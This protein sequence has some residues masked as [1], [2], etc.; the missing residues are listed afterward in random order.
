MKKLITIFTSIAAGLLFGAA[1]ANE[2]FTTGTSFESL[3]LGDK[4]VGHLVNYGDDGTQAGAELYWLC[5]ADADVE[6]GIITNYPA[7]GSDVPIESRPDLFTESHSNNCNYLSIDLNK[8]TP[9]LR[10]IKLYNDSVTPGTQ[11]VAVADCANGIFLDTL[12]KF[13]AAEEA[14]KEDLTDGD[15]IAIEYVEQEAETNVVNDVETNIVDAVSGFVVRAGYMGTELVQ[16]NYLVAAPA[17]FAVTNW[18]RLTVRTVSDIDGKGQLGFK[19]YLDEE[20][21]VYST[22]DA[23][24]ATAAGDSFED[25]TRTIFPSVLSKD[26]LNGGSLSAVAF[27]GNGCI[28]DVIFTTEAPN[29]VKQ[30]GMI[31]VTVTFDTGVT[32]VTLTAGEFVTNLAETGTCDLPAEARTT[33]FTISCLVDDD[34]GGYQ[35]VGIT[36]I[37]AGGVIVADGSQIS[38]GDA[39]A[40]ELAVLAKRDNAYYMDG[41]TKVGFETLSAAFEAAPVGATLKL[42]YDYSVTKD[43]VSDDAP[44]FVIAKNVV[45]DLNGKELDGGSGDAR[46]LFSVNLGCSLTVIDSVSGDE[47]SIVYGGTFGMFAGDGDT[48]I[49]SSTDYGPVIIGAV[50]GNG[51]YVSEIVRGKFTAADNTTAADEFVCATDD[52]TAGINVIADD[53]TVDLVGD[54]W[55]VEPEGAVGTYSITVTPTENATYSAVYTDSGDAIEPVNNVYT[56]V[57]GKTITITATP[58]KGFEYASQPDGWTLSEGVITKVVD[59]A[60]A[61][62]APTA[63][64]IGTYEVV[65]TPASNADY[66]AVY[67]NDGSTVTFTDNIVT[68]AVHYAIMIT[69]TPKTGYEYATTPDGW[70]AGANGVIT[71]V[72]DG[73]CTVVIPEPTAKSNWPAGWNSGNEPASMVTAFNTWIAAGNDPTAANAEAAFLVGVNVANYTNDFAAASISIAN[74]KVVITGNYD[75]T[76]INGALA[77]KMGDA[78]NALNTTTAVAKDALV[79]GAISLTPALGETKKFYKLV[80]GYPAE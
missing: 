17:D 29:F 12:V 67:T 49:G 78:P 48:I 33:G 15:K 54:Y 3:T 56:V 40:I 51:G 10:T 73:P 75:L 44:V 76:K 77:V 32:N 4:N 38:I 57:S 53:S 9:L 69:A 58:A 55:V 22:D 45:L 31:P 79:E 39:L 28:D 26:D 47:G 18:H 2:T 59:D 1:Q 24:F 19:I 60:V 46:A 30:K 7:V 80:I 64:V 71:K 68:V 34:I 20:E 43:V 27:S 52:D 16:T 21:L 41:D 25:S 5:A 62:P 36:N 42:G 11:Q 66:A 35:L 37:T 14:F 13:T 70:T 61:I 65:V 23:R 72:V 63:V 8:D 6:L 74:G 50:I